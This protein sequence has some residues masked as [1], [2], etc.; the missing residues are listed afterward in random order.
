[1]HSSIELTII[2]TETER[3]KQFVE[4]TQDT[5]SPPSPHSKSELLLTNLFWVKGRGICDFFF[6]SLSYKNTLK[7]RSFWPFLFVWQWLKLGSNFHEHG[8]LSWIGT[9]RL[10][11]PSRN[12]CPG[13]PMVLGTLVL[14]VQCRSEG[15]LVPSFISEHSGAPWWPGQLSAVWGAVP[16]FSTKMGVV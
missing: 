3:K 4:Y 5:P 12:Q 13:K 2:L 11:F 9:S 8:R 1:M 10:P 15:S 16:A 14:G 6:L 7:A